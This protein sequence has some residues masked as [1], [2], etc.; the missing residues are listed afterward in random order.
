MESKWLIV[1]EETHP[2]ENGLSL[3]VLQLWLLLPPGA[4]RVQ[5]ICNLVPGVELG[6]NFEVSTSDLGFGGFS[7]RGFRV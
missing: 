7:F 4:N 6:G 2:Q 3:W 1:A 5:D